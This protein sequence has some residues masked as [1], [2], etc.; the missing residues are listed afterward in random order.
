MIKRS[1]AL[2]LACTCAFGHGVHASLTSIQYNEA[3]R[4]LEII[5]V[6]S[7][8]DME[9]VLRRDTGK[10]V[11]IDR[12]ADQLVFGYIAKTLELRS[13]QAPLKLQWVG[14]EVSVQKVTAYLEAKVPDGTS[15]DGMRIRN[16]LLLDLLNDQVNILSV[17]RSG[18]P[19]AKASEHLFNSRGTW[20]TVKLP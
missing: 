17:K 14:M 10:Q 19:N 8:D 18:K 20:Q 11:E 13:Q 3:A 2:L 6:M 9:A 12:G 5:M 15:V 7:A 16:D 4:S 1:L